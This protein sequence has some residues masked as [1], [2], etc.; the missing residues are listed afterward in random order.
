[1]PS[2]RAR[3][4]TTLPVG[5]LVSFAEATND[6]IITTKR[7]QHHLYLYDKRPVPVAT[8]PKHNTPFFLIAKAARQQ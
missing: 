7:S 3:A 6:H 8:Q 5:T 2:G 4:F 1:V